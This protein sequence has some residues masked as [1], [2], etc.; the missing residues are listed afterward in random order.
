MHSM[1]DKGEGVSFKYQL[2]IKVLTFPSWD[3]MHDT[4]SY[5]SYTVGIIYIY[6]LNFTSI[7]F[8]LFLFWN[9]FCLNILRDI[10]K[11]SYIVFL[12]G[13]KMA[14]SFY[15]WFKIIDINY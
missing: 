15:L 4:L 8:Y 7:L 5:S 6:H 2:T 12:F 9:T 13:K 1:F 11:D 10:K 3:I 14:F